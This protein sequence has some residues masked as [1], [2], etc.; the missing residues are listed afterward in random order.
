MKKKKIRR[1]KVKPAYWLDHGRYESLDRTSDLASN[2]SYKTVQLTV[3]EAGW[4]LVT[5][6]L[7]LHTPDNLRVC[8]STHM[9]IAFLLTVVD[10][11]NTF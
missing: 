4:A 1:Q 2:H 11:V 8:S 3:R 10:E 7:F 9:Y 5:V 6:Y